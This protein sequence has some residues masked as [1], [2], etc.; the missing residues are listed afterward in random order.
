MTMSSNRSRKC[1]SN[2][3]HPVGNGG[4]VTRTSLLLLLIAVSVTAADRYD[5]QPASALAVAESASSNV[6]FKDGISNDVSSGSLRTSSIL[7]AAAASSGAIPFNVAKHH[8]FSKPLAA[9]NA[10][11]VVA[12]K[13]SKKQQQTSAAARAEELS[14]QQVPELQVGCADGF[15]RA[16]HHHRRT[17]TGL[18]KKWEK[19]RNRSRRNKRAA[20]PVEGERKRRG[21]YQLASKTIADS[22]PYTPPQAAYSVWQP[23]LQ[24]LARP[25][26]IPMWGSA[27]RNPVYFPPQPLNPPFP[28]DNP[29]TSYLPP[30]PYLPPYP[31]RREDTNEG[32]TIM[33]NGAS[34]TTTTTLKPIW[35]DDD[36]DMGMDGDE[37][38]DGDMVNT[39]DI[40]GGDDRFTGDGPVWGS[41]SGS[42][43]GSNSGNSINRIPTRRPK[44]SGATTSV[45]SILH[46][47]SV[48]SGA[49]SNRV[50]IQNGVNNNL[51][52]LS[53]SILNLMRP[54]QIGGNRPN[55]QQ[56][57]DID[58]TRSPPRPQRTTTTTTPRPT[59]SN[60]SNSISK[61]PSRCVWAIVSCCTA[62]SGQVDFGCFEELGCQGPFW[63]TN[64]CDSEVA[65]AA[66]ANALNF[67]G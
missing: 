29:R 16:D 60:D 21:Y 9:A 55:M 3:L 13:G 67:Y 31:P 45:P 38:G 59:T 66:I 33:G 4:T 2:V 30:M 28:L 56:K 63:D 49:S 65:K 5:Q 39:D 10:E 8:R 18:E 1:S 50:D 35:D 58:F 20:D 23:S 42:S 15:I 40:G 17:S 41:S 14:S 51:P 24:Q 61:G 34:T 26:F 32:G 22:R 12:A 54:N 11:K 44:V 25:Y 37:G 52:P 7:P 36:M 6:L 46:G 64:P 57:P 47:T 27:G 43:S 53:N 48:N 19:K 62:S